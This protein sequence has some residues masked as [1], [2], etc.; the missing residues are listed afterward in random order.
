MYVSRPLRLTPAF[1]FFDGASFDTIGY[2][3]RRVLNEYDFVPQLDTINARSSNTGIGDESRYYDRPN[4]MKRQ[5][6]VESRE[7]VILIVGEC[8]V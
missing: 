4:S 3:L 6:G 7:A 1:Q 5:F 8:R 2:S